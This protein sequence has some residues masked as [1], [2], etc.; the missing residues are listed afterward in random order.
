MGREYDPQAAEFFGI[1]QDSA[2]QAYVRELGLE[3][4][5]TSERP[6]LPWTFRLADDPA[7][8]AFAIPGGFVY[9][10]R[11]LLSA[12]NS[13]AELAG[14]VGHE[15]GHVTARHSV[16]QM[17]RQQLQQIGLVAGMV[18]SEHVRQ[19]GGMLQQGLAI[20]NLSYSRDDESEA[21]RLGV[22]Y[23]T[24]GGYDARALIDVMET[25]AL[26]SGDAE[27]RVPEWQL[28]H[29]YP[30]N[31]RANIEA[32]LAE[33]GVDYSGA[34]VNRNG[35][36]RRIDG[37]VYGLDPREGYF[38]GTRFHHPELAFRI[39]FP[40]GWRS[41]NQKTVVGAIAPDQDALI[42][43][44]VAADATSPSAALN[45]FV[46][47]DGVDS[48]NVRETS[49]NGLPAA[50]AEFAAQTDDGPIQGYVAYVAYGELVY[51]ILGYAVQSRWSNHA[52]AVQATLESFARET[53]PQVLGVRPARLEVVQV[54]RAMSFAEFLKAYPSSV[55]EAEVGRINRLHPDDRVEGGTLLKRVTGGELP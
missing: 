53:D 41:V 16:S 45:A 19:Y 26:T 21:D 4:A 48:R 23:M 30:E 32:L 52:R 28:T 18:F 14:V 22:R 7:V 35:Y 34:T 44:S 15:I 17:S 27:D 49:Y 8:N 38:D 43:L 6:Q 25:L 31:R 54:P 39:D 12:L 46:A 2:L 36:L 37:M 29:P 47:Q 42:A 20:L 40:S 1:Y 55:P 9:V 24:R 3:L 10:T 33:T 50:Q 51:Q 11:G 13:E 5:A